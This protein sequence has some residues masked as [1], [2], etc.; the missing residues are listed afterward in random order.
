[1]AGIKLQ[2][3]VS[4]LDPLDPN[5]L[6]AVL[7]KAQYYV[8]LNQLRSVSNR[9]LRVGPAGGIKEM[10]YNKPDGKYS[11]STD[12]RS[13]RDELLR[14]AAILHKNKKSLPYIEIRNP[15]AKK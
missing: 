9:V 11:L 13:Q 15:S 3:Y 14:K 12:I 7:D 4:N 1:M 8:D 5:F 2:K 10:T 6:T